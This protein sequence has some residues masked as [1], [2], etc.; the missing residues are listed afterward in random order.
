MSI[1]K[2]N[3]LTAL[4][5][6]GLGLV[7]WMAASQKEAKVEKKDRS[8]PG[9]GGFRSVNQGLPLQYNGSKYAPGQVLVKFRPT[10]SAQSVQTTIGAYESR[11]VRRIP[12]INV[13]QLQI[14]GSATVEEM[15]YVLGQNPDV[16]YAEP[17][18][19]TAITVSPNDEFFWRQYALYNSGDILA[20]PGSPQGKSRADIKATAAWEETK[21]DGDIVIAVIDTGVDLRHPDLKNKIAN[22]GRD[23]V[24][25]DFEATDD[26]GHGT[27]VAG[28]AAA[29]TN[30]S[31]GIAGVAWNCKVLPVKV[32]DKGG[33]GLYSWLI[34]GINWA[35]DNGAQVINMSLGADAYSDALKEAVKY[36]YDKGLVLVA[37][38]GNTGGSVFYPAAFD[39]YCLAVAATD[40]SDSW[41]PWSNVGAQVDV[42]APG[43]FIL[44]LVPTWYWGPSSPP[45]SFWSGTSMAA[46]HVSGLA[47]LVKSLKP[48]LKPAEIMNV[49]R[50][51]ADDVNSTTLSGK[52]DQIGYGRINMEKALVPL[53]VK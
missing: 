17:N 29:E 45:Y 1:K 24:N 39:D 20:I 2:K 46:P 28:I 50:Y 38:A 32:V 52:D 41:V 9:R 19:T 42:A 4:L 14:P 5:F 40:Y 43:V 31:Q 35:A 27:H 44:S 23:F 47:A 13:Y 12:Q 34:E 10:V 49:I 30:N 7:L 18:Y 26:H 3:K 51:S 22:S 15:V 33:S 53:K 21:G 6:L 37:A 8:F 36:A 16:V 11:I 48:W 25:D